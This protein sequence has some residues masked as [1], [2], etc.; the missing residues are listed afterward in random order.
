MLS[1]SDIGNPAQVPSPGSAGVFFGLI[2]FFWLD[3]LR[4]GTY[5]P[6]FEAA[7][8]NSLVPLTVF[9]LTF[10]SSS[11]R[12]NEEVLSTPS[13][14]WF[15]FYLFLFAL[16]FVVADV[17]LYVWEIFK[18]VLG[19]LL[20][21]Y[22]IVRQ[23]VTLNRLKTVM[24]TLVLLHVVLIAMY[25]EVLLNP[26]VRAPL[27]GTFLG[28]GNDFSWSVCIV[29]PFALFLAQSSETWKGRYLFYGLSVV[30]TLAVIGTQS[31]G[32]TLALAAVMLYLAIRSG[33][34]AAAFAGVGA[35]V[36]I[37][38]LFAPDAYFDRMG[39]LKNYEDDGS[40]QGRILAWKTA[41][42]MAF[43]HPLTG[44]GPGHFGVKF[45][46]KYKP[47]DYVGP[48]LNAHS[49]YFVTLGELGFP[50]ILFLVGLILTNFARNRSTY[51]KVRSAPS[52][53]GVESARL[54][55]AMQ[56][57]LIGYAVAG[58]FL[59]G[60]HYPHLFVLA[61]VMESAR[62]IASVGTGVTTAPQERRQE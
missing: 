59:S 38:L 28:D 45:G 61:G 23:V 11:G 17:R 19:Y 41:R 42:S 8:I 35:L 4:P 51:R 34:K 3:Y 58:A 53:V 52:S 1:R 31:R 13:S 20:I 7:K 33:R 18:A 54:V 43:D 60:V 24:R 27:A 10:V 49:I 50:G 37:V 55:V 16:Q 21:Y 39:T 57:S 44:V 40:A 26:D 48:Y 15:F 5:F 36:V 56:A 6:F 47:P 9:A 25:P 14:K 22:V 12:S 2:L 30:L 46:F 32:G 29:I 62:Y